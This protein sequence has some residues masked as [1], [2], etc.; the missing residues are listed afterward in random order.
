MNDTSKRPSPKCGDCQSW[1]KRA[2][3]GYHLGRGVVCKHP[4]EKGRFEQRE[5]AWDAVQL[6]MFDTVE[7]AEAVA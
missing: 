5:G 1:Q 6:E 2:G 4:R 3:C 7:V